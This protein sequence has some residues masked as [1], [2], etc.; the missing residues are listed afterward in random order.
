MPSPKKSH[1]FLLIAMLVAFV[2]ALF[3]QWPLLRDP[4]LLEPDFRNF[5]LAHR[6]Q[7][8]DL[9]PGQELDSLELG[10]P[11]Y[12]AMLWGASQFVPPAVFA[13]LLIFPLLLLS[14]YFLFRIGQKM[15]GPG[16]ALAMCLGFTVF[17]LAAD[18]EVSVTA[19]VQRSF[20]I[21]LLLMLLY[22]LMQER[23]RG[24]IAV[25]FL[26][27]LIYL[28]IL[29]VTLMTTV[30]ALA[31]RR[32]ENGWRLELKRRSLILLFL[33]LLLVIV[34]LLP[35]VLTKLVNLVSEG[36]EAWRQGRHL[37]VDPYYGPDGLRSMFN[38]F[39]IVGRGGLVISGSIFVQVYVLF[40]LALLIWVVR[41]KRLHPMPGS[42]QLLL[43]SS[44]VMFVLAWLGILLTSSWILYLP[45]RY[46][47]FTLF[48]WLVVFVF[49]NIGPALED[50][51]KAL[52]RHKQ[53]LLHI[54]I[55]ILI[56]AVTAVVAT[57][58]LELPPTTAS[59]LWPAMRV[60]LILLAL[61]ALPLLWLSSRRTGVKAPSDTDPKALR[62][63]WIVLGLMLLLLAPYYIRLTG[64]PMHRPSDEDL[65]LFDYL[66]TLPQDV[67]IAGDP[68]SL[69]DVHYYAR[70]NTLA[71][72]WDPGADREL[73]ILVEQLD[74]YYAEDS[75]Q[76][77]DFCREYGVDYLVVNESTTSAAFVREGEI[78][79]EPANTQLLSRVQGRNDFVLAQ[80][81]QDKR[82]F[83]SGDKFVVTCTADSLVNISE[84]IS[85]TD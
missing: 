13:K 67:M 7:N 3:V 34:P 26:S 65:A 1:R 63:I 45:S 19:G 81:P 71:S 49:A 75:E 25:V 73:A 46:T 53:R 85:A 5:Y 60:A 40:M 84:N 16:T 23:Y 59:L 44:F 64:P 47:Q 80:I 12:T 17:I 11:L 35:F 20:A 39:P 33:V 77:L 78:I 66:N 32:H 41:R 58:D 76:L 51:A 83:Q 54:A 68:C 57:A 24:A 69:D 61:L 43:L 31:F 29:P 70:R 4:H 48:L 36:L 27:G 10:S 37:L 22:V 62:R 30:L 55:P 28:P 79:Y 18:T 52:Q 15:R 82:L 74:A 6:A 9:F 72:C 2:L 38:V 42:F 50:L 14:V 21:P 8:P 56:L